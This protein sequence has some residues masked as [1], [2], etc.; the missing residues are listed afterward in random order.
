MREQIRRYDCKSLALQD[1]DQRLD[2]VYFPHPAPIP[3]KRGIDAH[4]TFMQRDMMLLA[5]ATERFWCAWM[6]ISV[7]RDRSASR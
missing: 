3:A 5:T 1:R 6:P 2:A 4:G 7:S